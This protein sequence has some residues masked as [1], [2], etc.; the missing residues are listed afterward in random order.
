MWKMKEWFYVCFYLNKIFL[1]RFIKKISNRKYVLDGELS[2]GSDREGFY[3]L[4]CMFMFIWILYYLVD[5]FK[6]YVK[7]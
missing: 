3:Y 2:V 6:I 5:L 4:W 1:D 7:L